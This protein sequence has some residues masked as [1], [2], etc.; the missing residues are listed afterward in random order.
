MVV[1]F[2]QAR[3]MTGETVPAREP[4]PESYHRSKWVNCA[5]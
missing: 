2:E 1:E 4:L 3:I 5:W